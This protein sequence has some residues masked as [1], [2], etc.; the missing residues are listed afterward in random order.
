MHVWEVAD[1]EAGRERRDPAAQRRAGRLRRDGDD[2]PREE[3]RH[4]QGSLLGDESG[5]EGKADP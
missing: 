4:R 1:R 2:A 3:D 5:G